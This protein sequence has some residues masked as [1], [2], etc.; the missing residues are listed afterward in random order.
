MVELKIWRGQKY[1]EEGLE[2]LSDY[3][4]KYSLKEGY[5]LIYDF[6]K[7]KQYKEKQISFE[8]KDI[9]AVWVWNSVFLL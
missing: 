4:D 6:N 8:D 2:Q 5:L 1:H 7:K 9:F 3:L